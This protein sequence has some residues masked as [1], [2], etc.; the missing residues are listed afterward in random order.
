[1]LCYDLSPSALDT[2][3]SIELRAERIGNMPVM[4]RHEARVHRR[5]AIRRAGGTTSIEG[6]RLPEQEIAEFLNRRLATSDD[7]AEPANIITL[8]AYEFVDYVGGQ[9]DIPVDELVIRELNR[10]FMHGSPEVVTPGSYRRGQKKVGLFTPPN[11][12]DVLLLMR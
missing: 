4:P 9:H 10:Q 6:V 1:M 11:Q 7:E 2:I 3:A 12:G 5:V 8:R